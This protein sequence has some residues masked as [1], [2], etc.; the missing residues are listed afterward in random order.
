MLKKKKALLGVPE[1]GAYTK[2]K[3]ERKVSI[4]GRHITSLRLVDDIAA[5]AEEE[6]ELGALLESLAK[7]C[8]SCKMEI[9]G[10]K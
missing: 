1:L 4:G 7:T 3:K 2:R 10:E 6:L 5:A 8:T 9:S